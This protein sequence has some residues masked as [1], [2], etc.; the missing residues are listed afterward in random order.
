M[1]RC[2]GIGRS[3]LMKKQEVSNVGKDC[4][5]S[6]N[7]NMSGINSQYG[8]FEYEDYDE[9]DCDSVSNN[10]YL[11]KNPKVGSDSYHDLSKIT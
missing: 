7:D 1:P 4:E 9:L 2:C 6:A 10:C 5:K 11:L 8:E 3:R